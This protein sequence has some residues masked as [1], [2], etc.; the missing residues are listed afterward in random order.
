MTYVRSPRQSARAGEDGLAAR[1]EAPAIWCPE[2][3]T[4]IAQAELNDL[5]RETTFYTLA[6]TLDDGA[7]LPIATTPALSF[8]TPAVASELGKGG[9][10][11]A[12]PLP[13]GRQ[14][15][16]IRGEGETDEVQRLVVVLNFSRELTAKL[17][18]R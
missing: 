13:D 8:G 15:V 4:A 9:V 3:Q 10:Y 7:T 1:A 14:L 2:C 17:A 11:I 16:L 18:A 12:D 6:F 5:E